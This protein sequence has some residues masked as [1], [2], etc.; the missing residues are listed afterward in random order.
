MH[1]MVQATSKCYKMPYGALVVKLAFWPF[2]P[3]ST[4]LMKDDRNPAKSY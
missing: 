4:N 2:R 1:Y 3:T